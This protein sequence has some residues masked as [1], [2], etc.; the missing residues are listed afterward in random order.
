MLG[1]R[2][3]ARNGHAR[4]RNLDKLEE[5]MYRSLV[6]LSKDRHAVLVLGQKSSC[7]GNRPQRDR[8]GAALRNT[9]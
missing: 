5:W 2:D 7:I 9:W 3:I 8:L 6:N 4:G 1:G